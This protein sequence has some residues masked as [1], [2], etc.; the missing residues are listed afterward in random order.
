MRNIFQRA[1][2]GLDMT[3]ARDAAY[4]ALYVLDRPELALERARALVPQLEED[5]HVTPGT[6]TREFALRDPDGYSVY[7]SEL[8]TP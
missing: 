6:G 3:H 7:I 2:D 8:E 5:P 4:V 1:L